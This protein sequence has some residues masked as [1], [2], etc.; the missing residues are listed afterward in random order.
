MR[1]VRSQEPR[2]DI[3]AYNIRMLSP[4]QLQRTKEC[5]IEN[6]RKRY[7]MALAQGLPSSS[8]MHAYLY[9]RIPSP[10]PRPATCTGPVLSHPYSPPLHG[11]RKV[12]VVWRCNGKIVTGTEVRTVDRDIHATAPVNTD[13][14]HQ[15][16]AH[17]DTVLPDYDESENVEEYSAPSA[18]RQKHPV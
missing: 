8:R 3:D 2:S 16:R 10:P 4:K 5:I 15:K 13:T 18:T 12:K 14:N 9:G 1:G 7:A 11:T 17:D 6:K